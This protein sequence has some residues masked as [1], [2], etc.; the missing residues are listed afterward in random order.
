VEPK[1]NSVEADTIDVDGELHRAPRSGVNPG[2]RVEQDGEVFTVC[3]QSPVIG[4]RQNF[5][6]E[7]LPANVPV[8]ISVHVVIVETLTD[9]APLCNS[10][11]CE[12]EGR[13]RLID[14]H[15]PPL[16]EPALLAVDGVGADGALDS[17]LPDERT[18]VGAAAVWVGGVLRC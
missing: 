18:E 16:E 1:S 4:G 9:I 15:P 3:R 14:R 13:C 12:I 8:A 2:Q 17:S 10:R 7:E 11:L 6:N 5:D